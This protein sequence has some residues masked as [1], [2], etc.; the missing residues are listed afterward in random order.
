MNIW[1]HPRLVAMSVFDLCSSLWCSIRESNLRPC[2]SADGGLGFGCEYK[3]ANTRS[4]FQFGFHVHNRIRGSS[5]GRTVPLRCESSKTL[6]SLG[7]RDLNGA[8]TGR[9]C[10]TYLNGRP[11]KIAKLVHEWNASGVHVI[12]FDNEL[13]QDGLSTAQ[14]DPEPGE[15]VPDA[16]ARMIT[17]VSRGYQVIRC[18][19]ARKGLLVD[20]GRSVESSTRRPIL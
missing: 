5:S 20:R 16:A 7:R 12:A 2:G 15:L 4:S 3:R 13:K 6:W 18:L 10:V 9:G 19:G 17:F 1:R 11:A 8:G 14:M